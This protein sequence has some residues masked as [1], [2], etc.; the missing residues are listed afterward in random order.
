MVLGWWWLAAIGGDLAARLSGWR[1]WPAGA[2]LWLGY[3]VASLVAC[4]DHLPEPAWA[5]VLAG[6]SIAWTKGY[7]DRRFR[8]V[9][10]RWLR[11]LEKTSN[12]RGDRPRLGLGRSE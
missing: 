1:C 4:A 12:D 2:V 7:L 11:T 10:R 8:Q 9:D 5:A 3:I 6:G